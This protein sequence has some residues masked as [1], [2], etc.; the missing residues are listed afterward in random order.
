MSIAIATGFEDDAFVVYNPVEV[1]TVVE[2]EVSCAIYK[3]KN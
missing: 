3:V 1:V 2:N